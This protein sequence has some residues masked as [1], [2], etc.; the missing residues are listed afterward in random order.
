MAELLENYQKGTQKTAIYPDGGGYSISTKLGALMYL[1]LKLSGEAGEVSEKIGKLYRDNLEVVGGT[2]VLAVPKTDYKVFR[3]EVRKEL[4]D[5]L[6]YISQ[7][8]NKLDLS[9]REVM[10]ENQKKLE[11]RKLKDTLKGSGDDR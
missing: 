7:L 9:L 3:K 11:L 8:C 1:G 4:G 5:V 10:L 2:N 6:W